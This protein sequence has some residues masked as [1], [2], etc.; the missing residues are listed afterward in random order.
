VQTGNRTL[1]Q[2]LQT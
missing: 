1:G 2:K